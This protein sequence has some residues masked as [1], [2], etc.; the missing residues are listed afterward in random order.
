MRE[1]RHCACCGRKRGDGRSDR[2]WLYWIVDVHQRRGD[3]LIGP[4]PVQV[5]FCATCW[6]V[7]IGP[8]FD[9]LAGEVAS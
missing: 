1:P 6:R 2:G 5:C 8:Q 9:K 4:L 3:A 7:E